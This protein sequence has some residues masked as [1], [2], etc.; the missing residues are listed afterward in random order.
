MKL[1]PKT[2]AEEKSNS[3]EQVP[4][5]DAQENEVDSVST[6]DCNTVTKHRDRG[7]ASYTA[8][9]RALNFVGK[10]KRA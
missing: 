4:E 3:G 6:D 2:S 5:E 8:L 7:F 1:K 10:T 9:Q